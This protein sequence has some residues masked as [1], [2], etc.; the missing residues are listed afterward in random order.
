MMYCEKPNPRDRRRAPRRH[1]SKLLPSRIL[2]PLET[3]LK[4]GLKVQ[5]A[6]LAPSPDMIS[7]V[8]RIHFCIHSPSIDVAGWCRFDCF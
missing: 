1:N 2:I 8:I 3:V 4:E 5:D 7:Q 6:D